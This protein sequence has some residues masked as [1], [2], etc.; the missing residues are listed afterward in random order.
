[1]KI[2]GKKILVVLAAAL[3]LF[4]LIIFGLRFKK[5]PTYTR[6]ETVQEKCVE[7]IKKADFSEIVDL[8]EQLSE[9]INFR[10]KIG[11]LLYPASLF[12]NYL[13]CEILKE[14]NQ[15]KKEELVGYTTEVWRRIVFH[16]Y[17]KAWE[18]TKIRLREIFTNPEEFFIDNLAFGKMAEIC[19]EKLPINCKKDNGIFFVES[20]EWCKNICDTL[21]QYE[22]DKDK[23]NREVINL[24]DPKEGVKD[25]PGTSFFWQLAA[26]YRFGGK[27][28]ALKFC[29]NLTKPGDKKTCISMAAVFGTKDMGCEASFDKLAQLICD[30]QYKN[31]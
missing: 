18:E 5:T 1:M 14:Q 17:D 7:K 24:K 15:K 21:A 16:N 2:S 3:C 27:D 29:D 4:L 12:K 9:D 20:D 30:Y 6:V 26:A 8:T 25:V 19:P 23:L 22:K 11:S 13:K 31:Y 10:G 28:L